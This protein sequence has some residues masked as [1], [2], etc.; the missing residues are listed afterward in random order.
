MAALAPISGMDRLLFKDDCT[1]GPATD[2]DRKSTYHRFMW[3]KVL[4]NGLLDKFFIYTGQKHTHLN[5][6]RLDCVLLNTTLI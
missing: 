2:V 5:H 3:K 6:A 1:S 4:T